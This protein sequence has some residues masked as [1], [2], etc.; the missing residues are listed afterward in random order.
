MTDDP[1]ELRYLHEVREA[2]VSEVDREVLDRLSRLSKLI[3]QV[4]SAA[5]WAVL[6]L[7][8]ILYKVW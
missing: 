8:V 7:A 5:H 6:L 3:A 1:D 2:Q 4:R